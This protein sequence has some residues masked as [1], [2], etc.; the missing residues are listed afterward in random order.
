[1]V[2][3]AQT[4]GVDDYLGRLVKYIPAEIVGFYLTAA[5]VIPL[6]QDKKPNLLA[7]WVV[8]G[9]GF[10]LVPV[11]FWFATT[12]GGKPPLT[13]QIVFATIAYP[14]WVFAIGGPFAF[15][16]WYRSWIGSLFLLFVTVLFAMYKPPPGS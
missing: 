15:L 5:G 2:P 16:S 8:F 11:Y 4:T 12:R 13:C 9:L 6:G 14:V 10:V 7:L 1:M 3:A